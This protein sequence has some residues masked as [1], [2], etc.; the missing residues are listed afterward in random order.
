MS[1]FKLK[2]LRADLIIRNWSSLFTKAVGA[3]GLSSPG[4][5][6]GKSAPARSSYN[7]KKKKEKKG[8]WRE[9]DKKKSGEIYWSFGYTRQ[10]P[11]NLNQLM[12]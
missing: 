3:R 7:R 5:V 6:G 1:W 11:S 10:V 2:I 4:I 9:S 12:A 8:V